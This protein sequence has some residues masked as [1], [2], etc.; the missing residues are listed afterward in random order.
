MKE[1][2]TNKQ[3]YIKLLPLI[4]LC[5]FI[6]I[7]G[8]GF[9]VGGPIIGINIGGGDEGSFIGFLVG[10]VI[11][12]ILTILYQTFIANIARSSIVAMITK[13][14][15]T[16]E[17]PTNVVTEG[18]KLSK[19]RFASITVLFLISQGIRSATGMINHGVANISTGG[20][21]GAASTAKSILDSISNTL[22]SYLSDC[23]LA[24]V[25]Y[26]SNLKTGKAAI[27]GLALF[28]KKGRTLLA[29][30]KRVVVIGIIS[31]IAIAG[32]SFGVSFTI[33]H[34]NSGISQSI[35]DAMV[36]TFDD[37]SPE[38]MNIAIFNVI[39]AFVIALYLWTVIHFTFVRPFVLIGVIRNYIESGKEVEITEEDIKSTIARAPRLSKIQD[40]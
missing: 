23:C 21:R 24:W 3:I 12:V 9:L 27:E 2:Y 16:N 22:I 25:F 17:I 36:N 15:T 38:L 4:I 26:R 6:D 20:H 7:I 1:K 40:K 28:F 30:A 19:S 18:F 37:L 39:F 13:I 5:F 31:F 34:F 32:I 11:G 10:F 29:N 33:L 8:F 14:E 35:I